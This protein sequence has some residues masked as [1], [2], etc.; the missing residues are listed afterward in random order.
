M[1]KIL[2]LDPKTDY[3]DISR[4][5]GGNGKAVVW[6][7]MGAKHCALHYVVMKPGENNIPHVHTAT[8]DVIYVLQGEGF[9]ENGDTG[10]QT[11]F[12]QGQVIFVPVG[13]KHAVQAR[14]GQ[15]YIAVGAQAPFDLEFYKRSGLTW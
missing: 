3:A 6:P 5:V 8:E 2:V 14:G 7:G 4:S 1:N 11:P 13:V 9:V 10:E 12:K 15:D